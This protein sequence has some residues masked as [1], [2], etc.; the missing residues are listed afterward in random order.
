MSRIIFC[1]FLKRKAEGQDFQVYPG[2]IGDR[3]YNEI[4]KE[5]WGKWIEKQTILINEK[6]LKL[7][8]QEDRKILENEM[9]K[10]LFK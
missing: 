2:N 5:A 9:I 10:F 7:I 4:S 6:K 3:I 8:H 1:N